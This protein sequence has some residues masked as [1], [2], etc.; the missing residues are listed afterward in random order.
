M[1]KLICAK[2]ANSTVSTVKL[3]KCTVTRTLTFCAS[4]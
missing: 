1:A 2:R 3:V 4:D